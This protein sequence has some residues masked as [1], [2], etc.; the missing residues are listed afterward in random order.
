MLTNADLLAD[1]D[2]FQ[3]QLLLSA[4]SAILILRV[5]DGRGTTSSISLIV[6]T[7]ALFLCFGAWRGT[8]G[9]LATVC[10]TTAAVTLAIQGWVCLQHWLRANEAELHEESR[11]LADEKNSR[12]VS[13]QAG[14]TAQ[15]S[16][17]SKSILLRKSETLLCCLSVGASASVLFLAIQA[18]TSGGL[19]GGMQVMHLLAAAIA[20]GVAFACSVEL[21]FL[22]SPDALR[23]AVGNK[24]HWS[25]IGWIAL[26]VFL[27][28]F[29]VS[30]AIMAAAIDERS[31]VVE[32]LFPKVYALSL[33]VVHFVVWMVPHRVAG[34]Q[35]TGS[36]SQWTSL[37]LASWLGVL[38]LAV[39]NSLP[40]NWPWELLR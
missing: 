35:R 10:L 13:K 28:E 27:A 14:R 5:F 8:S 2:F 25:A 29:V 9:T 32:Q 17:N 40:N 11:Q 34:F 24:V 36:A 12:K 18:E 23:P 38:G 31:S 15:Q 39:V 16:D 20:A 1:M 22:S 26:I 37:T 3:V 33:L 19:I 30:A 4:C 21:T 6:S 7:I